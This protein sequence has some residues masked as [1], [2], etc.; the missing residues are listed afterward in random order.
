MA[1]YKA[2]PGSLEKVNTMP[3]FTD[4]K[5]DHTILKLLPRNTKLVQIEG[6]VIFAQNFAN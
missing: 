6:F 3:K 4:S 5:Y 1:Y 2:N